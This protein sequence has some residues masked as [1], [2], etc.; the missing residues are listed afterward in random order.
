[1]PHNPFRY[2]RSLRFRACLIRMLPETA[3]KQIYFRTSK[4][5][6]ASASRF[7]V[8]THLKCFFDDALV[9]VM[10]QFKLQA[11]VY[12]I[13]PGGRCRKAIPGV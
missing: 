9:F 5:G 11:F 13:L 6:F 12:D 1:M 10:S 7:Q 2:E 4:Q 3:G 8:Q